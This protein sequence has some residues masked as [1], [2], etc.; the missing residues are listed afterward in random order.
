MRDEGITYDHVDKLLQ[1]DGITSYQLAVID[2]AVFKRKKWYFLILDEAHYIKNFKSQRWQSLL[3]L[4]TQRRLLL[5]GTP[6]Q[7]HL[8]ELW[9]LLH[10]LMYIWVIWKR[11]PATCIRR[12]VSETAPNGDRQRASLVA[13][14]AVQDYNMRVKERT[15]Q[16]LCCWK[17]TNCS[18]CAAL[19]W[20]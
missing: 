1:R 7:N 9:S 11:P 6:L 16:T 19:G 8:M 14:A 5:S 2:T 18:C 10:F 15:H 12:T 17:S 13:A 20:G 3:T 4:N